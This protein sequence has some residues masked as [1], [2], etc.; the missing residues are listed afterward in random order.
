MVKPNELILNLVYLS[1]FYRDSSAR[2]GEAGY[3]L[4]SFES[5]V[6]SLEMIGI[7]FVFYS[8]SKKSKNRFQ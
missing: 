2:L 8:N 7:N 1:R 4:A 5:V 6:H 3:V